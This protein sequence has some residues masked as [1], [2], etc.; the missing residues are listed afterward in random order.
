MS[1]KKPL[2]LVLAALFLLGSLLAGCA[3]PRAEE[4]PPQ[5]HFVLSELEKNEVRVVVELDIQ[6]GSSQAQLTATFTPLLDGYHLYSKDLPRDGIAGVGRPTLLE[7]TH[8][9]QMSVNGFLIAD[10]AVITPTET[11]SG[12]VDPP[13]YPAGPVT[14]TLPVT[15][16][17]GDGNM[18]ADQISLTFMACG[19]IG[20]KPP[21]TDLVLEIEVPSAQKQ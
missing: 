7:L 12:F 4:A 9:S 1:V 5:D 21:V 15:L 18:V 3:A 16:P 10:R 6:P 19:P 2:Y 14:L 8:A 11:I 13:L 17:E 20:C